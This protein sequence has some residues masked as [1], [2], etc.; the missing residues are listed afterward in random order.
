MD[1]VKN[2]HIHADRIDVYH[3]EISKFILQDKVIELG[4]TML[5]IVAFAVAD[6]DVKLF[7]YQL[8][9]NTEWVLLT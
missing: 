4:G 7:T 5:A 9:A 2:I 6:G 8:N 3:T 1:L